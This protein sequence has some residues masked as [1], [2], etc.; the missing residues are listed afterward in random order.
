[1]KAYQ[2][3]VNI[4]TGTD[5]HEVR[6]KVFIFYQK[7]KKTSKRKT[8]IR[9]AY[10]QKDKIFLDFFW[11]HLFGQQNWRDR[12]RRLKYFPPAIELIRHSRFEPKSQE[13]PN[14]Q[15]EILHRFAGLTRENHL[16]YIQIKEDKKTSRKYLISVFPVL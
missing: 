6:K 12:I 9:S 14:K 2:T 13:N 11:S 5:F 1:M 15:G 7:I 16:F 3:G 4:V 8:Y 10:F